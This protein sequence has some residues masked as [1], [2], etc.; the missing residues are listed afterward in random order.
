MPV[1]FVLKITF[2]YSQNVSLD[3]LRYYLTKAKTDSNKIS[4]LYNIGNFYKNSNSDSTLKY[5]KII[6]AIAETTDYERGLAQAEVLFGLASSRNGDIEKAIEYFSNALKKYLQL[7]RNAEIASCFNNIGL[8][9]YFKGDY[10][11]AL[12]NYFQAIT[13][14]AAASD[15]SAAATAFG[16]IGIIHYQNKDYPKAREYYEKAIAMD[17]NLN[18]YVSVARNIGNLANVFLREA[19]LEIKKGDTAMARNFNTKAISMYNEALNVS[20]RMKDETG[21]ALQLGNVGNV[22]YAMGDTLKTLDYYKKA[23]AIYE[24][25]NLKEGMARNYGNIGYVYIELK[26]YKEAE[27][28]TLKALDLAQQIKSVALIN[29]FCENLSGLYELKGDNK[30]ALQFYKRYI[31]TRDSLYNEETTKKTVKAEM[32][33]EFEQK[34]IIAKQERARQKIIR[35]SFIGAFAMMFILAIA[36]LRGYKLKQKANQLISEQKVLVDIKNKEITDSIKYAKRIQ[37]SLFPTEKYIERNINNL[38]KEA[39]KN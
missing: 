39:N 5:A 30:S 6:L 28:Y 25:N 31:I 13:Y 19:E 16:N 27:E 4:I 3:T 15:K 1:L 20:L 17:K 35:N 37:Q 2:C 24:K 26:K 12:E 32:N 34:E 8:N 29:N 21:A 10:V 33:F 11:K 22:F 38:Q 7:N 18:N 36:V 23:L 9:F 14:S